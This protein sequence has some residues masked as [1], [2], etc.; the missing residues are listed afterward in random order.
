MN[1]SHAE[2]IADAVLYEGYLLYPYRAS[3]LKNRR[4][5]TFG[6]LCPPEFCRQ[7]AAG[8]RSASQTECLV[9]GHPGTSLSA[10][11]RFLQ[12]VDAAVTERQ[13]TLDELALQRL[14]ER[15]EE[16]TLL[17]PPLELSV[18]LGATPVVEGLF[19]LRL[20]I[21]NRTPFTGHDRE[22]AMAASLL[23]CHAVL[24]ARSGRFVSLT[25]PPRAWA[26]YAEACENLGTWPVLVGGPEQS[27]VLSSP[28]ILPDFPQVAPE[29]PGDLFDGT[30]IDELLSLRILTL[31]E[32]EKEAM[33]RGDERVRRLLERTED[34]SPEELL[35]LHGTWRREPA[36]ES[37]F[38][39]GQR[40]RLRPA[41]RADIF[42]LELRG[43][44]ATIV[45]VEV[46]LEGGVYLAVTV[47]EDPGQDLGRMGLPAH[48][49]FFRPEEVERL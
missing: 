30:E 1:W 31:G 44:E 9:E 27:V 48:R 25:D 38:G 40:V 34:L 49:F 29:S 20:H 5:W 13:I 37:V 11:V 23:S 14:R 36:T 17:F 26:P 28:I 12:V 43:K 16:R 39:P 45:S 18:T 7:A 8:D 33:R 22:E 32:S 46:D 24:G 10:K 3:A 2:R 6:V 35:A 41:G 19:K 42:D 47:D 15:P 21:A 4:R